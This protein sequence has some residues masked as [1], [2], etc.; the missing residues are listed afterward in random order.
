MLSLH[1][2][3]PRVRSEAKHWRK[4]ICFSGIPFLSFPILQYSTS[5]AMQCTTTY[6]FRFCLVDKQIRI[7]IICVLQATNRVIWLWDILLNSV[8]RSWLKNRGKSGV[9]H[10]ACKLSSHSHKRVLGWIT[11][12]FWLVTSIQYTV[13]IWPS[14]YCTCQM[15]I[16]WRVLCGLL[17]VIGCP[18][19]LICYK[20]KVLSH[21]IL[22]FV[23]QPHQ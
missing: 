17:Y 5:A 11:H 7:K 12:V 15:Q 14:W 13:H 19:L 3:W 2:H 10:H 22:S 9:S 18:N 21:V 20:I 16:L 4:S 8:Q 6:N 1:Y 23:T